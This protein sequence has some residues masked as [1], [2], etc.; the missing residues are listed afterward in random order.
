MKNT[1]L[2]VFALTA[3]GAC[4]A[5][6]DVTSFGAKA[7]GT[8]DCTAAIQKAIDRAAADGGG[9]AFVPGGGVYRTYTLHL[10][11]NVELK[12]DRGATLKGGDDPLKYPLFPPTDVWRRDRPIR[13]NARA[14][15]YAVG[16]TNVAVTGGGTIDGNAK[17]ETFHQRVNGVWTRMSDTEIPGKCMMFM[18]CRDVRLRDFRL[19]DP[20]GW[21]TWFLDCDAVQISGL[22]VHCDRERPNGDGL[23]FGGCRDVTVSDCILDTQDDAIIIRS[24]QEQMRAPRPCPTRARSA[25]A[26]PATRR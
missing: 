8:T 4:A 3:L 21:A 25:S 26:G 10:K 11:S 14:M 23:H 15:F 12:V 22:A 2:F 19:V 17:S 7:D 5:A 13:W 16:Q 1:V 24:H 9:T 18:G 6:Y 20:T